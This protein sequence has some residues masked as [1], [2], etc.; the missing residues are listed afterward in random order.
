MSPIRI[1]QCDPA[2]VDVKYAVIVA[3]LLVLIIAVLGQLW[4]IERNRRVDAEGRLAE[5]YLK[6]RLQEAANALA[7]TEGGE[8][9]LPVHRDELPAQTVQWNGQDKAVLI[10][11]EPA[12]KAMGFAP[13]D[14]IMVAQEAEP[15][16]GPAGSRLSR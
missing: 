8:R 14:V 16:A 13:G 7:V 5:M 9:V 1:E 2:R 12:G 15:S 10:L 4:L 3:A 11:G 6:E